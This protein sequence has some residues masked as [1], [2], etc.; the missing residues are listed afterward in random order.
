VSTAQQRRFP[1][2]VYWIALAIIL[3]VALAPVLSVIVAG[4]IADA[5]GCALDEGS[6]HP[7]IVN[8]EDI[9]STLYALGVMGWFML[10][11]IPLGAGA[12][13][14][15]AVVLIAHRL[16]WGRKRGDAPNG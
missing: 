8:G 11:T 2:W 4:S 15:W 7:C 14:L 1:W 6:V 16:Y 5:N 3:L 9:G 13:L 10:A 12:L